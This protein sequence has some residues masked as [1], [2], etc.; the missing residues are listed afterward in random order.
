MLAEMNATGHGQDRIGGTMLPVGPLGVLHLSAT[1][2]GAL[3]AGQRS[4]PSVSRCE[5]RSSLGSQPQPYSSPR[6]ELDIAFRRPP[7]PEQPPFE[8]RTVRRVGKPKLRRLLA[9]RK[10]RPEQ[11]SAV[12]R[13]QPE[14]GRTPQPALTPQRVAANARPLSR[15]GIEV[16]VHACNRPPAGARAGP[17]LT[18]VERN[19][20]RA[21]SVAFRC[22]S[23][24]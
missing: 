11:Q 22:L 23:L 15:A 1:Q 12:W 17:R 16:Q 3:T 20:G 7:Q 19:A 2:K 10:L 4:K 13:E 5:G 18:R 24:Q 8:V 9:S 21:A 14:R 6:G